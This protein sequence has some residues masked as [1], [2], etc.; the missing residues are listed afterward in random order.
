MAIYPE[1]SEQSEQS[2]HLQSPQ[3][4]QPYEIYEQSQQASQVSSNPESNQEERLNKNTSISTLFSYTNQTIPQEMRDTLTK[5]HYVKHIQ[6]QFAQT[7]T[8]GIL[9]HVNAVIFIRDE[10]YRDETVKA[11]QLI[12]YVDGAQARAELNNRVEIIIMKYR[13][14]FNL[15]VSVFEIKLSRGKYLKMHPYQEELSLLDTTGTCAITRDNYPAGITDIVTT[16]PD[17]AR[18]IYETLV[19]E[20]IQDEYNHS[21]DPPLQKGTIVTSDINAFISP[22]KPGKLQESFRRVLLAKQQR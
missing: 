21:D 17:R 15:F 9:R 12:V 14:L 20:A 18:I 4:Y 19:N 3:S 2:I 8:P 11:Y 13:E 1:Q 6:N 10:L 7:V 5:E 16:N 22:L